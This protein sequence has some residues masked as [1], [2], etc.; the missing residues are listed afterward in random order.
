MTEDMNAVI[1][2]IA[3]EDGMNKAIACNAPM[4]K[5]PVTPPSIAGT[6][7][8]TV[9]APDAA[10]AVMVEGTIRATCMAT[11]GWA[12]IVA[13]DE[14]PA[15]FVVRLINGNIGGDEEINVITMKDG[16]PPRMGPL[17]AESFPLAVGEFILTVE[18]DV[19][20]THASVSEG[21]ILMNELPNRV[22]A[23]YF[24]STNDK[25]EPNYPWTNDWP[26]AKE[27]QEGYREPQWPT[28]NCTLWRRSAV[29]KMD[30]SRVPVL[31]FVDG[32]IGDR[33]RERGYTFLMTDKVQCVH[34]PHTGRKSMKG[35]ART[36]AVNCRNIWASRGINF[37]WEQRDGLDVFSPHHPCI[38]FDSD[39]FR[40]V[41]VCDR[42]VVKGELE[43][44][45]RILR[46][47][48]RLELCGCK[49]DVN[50]DDVN[51]LCDVVRRDEPKN[52]VVMRR[53]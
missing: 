49:L 44:Y 51:S 21:M 18:Q 26:R 13:I 46:K 14:A 53:K 38:P 5:P 41:Y 12:H 29:D 31:E 27:W 17:V 6:T 8:N 23:L 9:F 37:D 40:E 20:I 47:D 45:M 35:I 24:Q 7:I 39:S 32:Y 48:G 50:Q 36:L 2:A 1:K 30:F 25:G 42:T 22:G 52:R 3:D 15:D 11:P 19:L 33:L 4:N 43:E 28:L 10:T 34:N 16:L